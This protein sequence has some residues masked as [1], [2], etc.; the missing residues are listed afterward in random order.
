M[1]RLIEM[2]NILTGVLCDA[3]QED[4]DL[5]AEAEIPSA[6]MYCADCNQRLCGECCKIYRKNKESQN[7]GIGWCTG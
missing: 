6:D 7:V 5:S 4:N 2:K 1:E 3:C